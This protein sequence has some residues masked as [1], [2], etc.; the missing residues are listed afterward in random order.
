MNRTGEIEAN[1]EVVSEITTYL[2]EKMDEYLRDNPQTEV[3]VF[4]A[5]QNFHVMMVRH[6][7]QRWKN[8]IP[9]AQIYRMADMTFRRMIRELRLPTKT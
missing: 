7:V 4:M 3:D 6:T 1:P 8:A 9:E 5:I 2:I